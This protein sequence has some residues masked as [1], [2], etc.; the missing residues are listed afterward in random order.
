MY[1]PYQ[2]DLWE[3][4]DPSCILDGLGNHLAVGSRTGPGIVSADLELPH[5]P[6]TQYGLAEATGMASMRQVRMVGRR[7]ETY[8]LG[9]F[10]RPPVLK[11]YTGGDA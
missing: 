10:A 5:E 4:C 3:G 9:G 2:R 8:K 7:P 11:R 1:I 6:P